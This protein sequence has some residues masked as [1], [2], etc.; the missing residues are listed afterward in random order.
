ML[1][2]NGV[3]ITVSR[4]DTATITFVLQNI[5][6]LPADSIVFGIRGQEGLL[7]QASASGLS[8]KRFMITV[9]SEIT[10]RLPAWG[11]VYDLALIRDGRVRSLIAPS[12]FIV[13]G[14]AHDVGALPPGTSIGIEKGGDDE[15]PNITIET[16]PDW[17][18]MVS[19]SRAFCDA[20]ADGSNLV[21][22]RLN[23]E[24]ET[25]EI[26]ADAFGNL[27]TLKRNTAYEK[28]DVTY[29]AGIPRWGYLL[30]YTA[31]ISASSEPELPTTEGG[32]ASDGSVV[33]RLCR[34]KEEV[35]HVPATDDD[36]SSLF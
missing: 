29:A 6:L 23:G 1:S 30:C 10:R 31:G 36:I 9:P 35:C 5:Q 22:T 14:T 25:L 12:A 15:M 11:C 19:I 3:N 21:L 13:S 33:W 16:A 27:E 7:T 4:G 26:T 32:L 2:T 34:L 18:D 20:S 28:G 17:T 24:S 8:G